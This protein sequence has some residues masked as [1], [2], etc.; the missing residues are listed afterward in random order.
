MVLAQFCARLFRVL[1]LAMLK[2][3]I[4][5]GGAAPPPG[6]S[7]L[8]HGLAV[9]DGLR[10]VHVNLGYAAP[11]SPAVQLGLLCVQIVVSDFDGVGSFVDAR[12]LRRAEIVQIR[13]ILVISIFAVYLSLLAVDELER[14]VLHVRL[15]HPRVN[16]YHAHI[17][18]LLILVVQ[19]FVCFL[20][21]DIYSVEVELFSLTC[22]IA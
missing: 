17:F 8:A 9:E 2:L 1:C 16:V 6:I 5:V 7:T 19:L 4:I 10:L 3:D 13:Q 11:T 22:L 15:V 20:T 12:V 18:I 14:E 21:L